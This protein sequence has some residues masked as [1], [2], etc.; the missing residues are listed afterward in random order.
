ML[1]M[2]RRI[3]AQVISRRTAE[4]LIDHLGIERAQS[5]VSDPPQNDVLPYWFVANQGRL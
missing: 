3:P 2:R 1:E 4:V 5:I